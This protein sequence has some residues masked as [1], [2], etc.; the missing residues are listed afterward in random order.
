M[1]AILNIHMA[2]IG[3]AL[4]FMMLPFMRNFGWDNTLMR[5][6]VRVPF[7]IILIGISR[8][9]WVYLEYTR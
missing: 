9:S 1:V 5:V 7:S 4:G 2:F 8:G 3:L 6:M